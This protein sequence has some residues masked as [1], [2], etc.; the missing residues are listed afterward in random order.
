MLKLLNVRPLLQGAADSG[1][2]LFI[3]AVTSMSYVML[4]TGLVCWIAS[5]LSTQVQRP[6]HLHFIFFI[7]LYMWS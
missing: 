5:E 4:E 6:R 1:V 7:V 2:G 3:M